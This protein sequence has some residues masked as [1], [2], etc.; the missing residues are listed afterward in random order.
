MKAIVSSSLVYTNNNAEVIQSLNSFPAAL[1]CDEDIYNC[2]L[3]IFPRPNGDVYVCGLE[4]DEPELT[5]KT[6]LT[7]SEPASGILP[8]LSS[9]ENGIH[10]LYGVT[11]KV[12]ESS[13]LCNNDKGVVT[14]CDVKES[15]VVVQACLRPLTEDGLPVIGYIPNTNRHALIATGHNCWGIL[16]G[17]ITGLIIAEL[18]VLGESKTVKDISAFEPGR[19]SSKTN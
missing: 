8:S 17:P 6:L 18:I 15:N 13:S 19:F 14:L 1:F 11:R 12:V 5:P 3:E 16:W 10:A 2:Q 7:I 9:I 4:I